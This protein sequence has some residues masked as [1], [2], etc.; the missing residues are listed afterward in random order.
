M[1]AQMKQE[2]ARCQPSSST[3][4][5]QRRLKQMVFRALGLSWHTR[6]CWLLSSEEQRPN[7]AGHLRDH[8]FHSEH[9]PPWSLL[10]DREWADNKT[11]SEMSSQCTSC[12]GTAYQNH[13]FQACRLFQRLGRKYS[14]QSEGPSWDAHGPV[15][16]QAWFEDWNQQPS[17]VMG[18]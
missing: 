12:F 2:L 9:R 10:F 16:D 3:Y 11:D 8:G 14:E 5:I 17:M 13:H 4:A 1:S 6:L 18:S 15:E 7:Q